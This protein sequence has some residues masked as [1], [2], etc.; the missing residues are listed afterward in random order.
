[1]VLATLI[2]GSAVAAEP[3]PPGA[4]I[5]AAAQVVQPSAGTQ[6]APADATAQSGAGAH[7]GVEDAAKTATGA[8]PSAG[9]GS[10]QSSAAPVTNPPAAQKPAANTPA[11]ASVTSA[12]PGSAASLLQVIFGLI[13]VLGLLGAALWAL[14]RFGGVRM[15]GGAPL[16]IIGGVSVGS[17]EKVLV[18]EVGDQ[19]LVVGVAPGR[20]SMLT[21]L[22]RGEQRD[23]ESQ[24]PAPD[25]GAW[26]KQTLEKRNVK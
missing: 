6:A 12:A 19:W 7:G 2:A 15:A 24:R 9:T 3:A 16:K 21:T 1:M 14:K 26:L 25:F 13:V 5:G 23:A 18:L 8:P 20:V 17:R 11:T 22:P 4:A 10:A